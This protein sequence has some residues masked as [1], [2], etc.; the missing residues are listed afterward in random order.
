MKLIKAL[1][2][3]ALIVEQDGVEKIVLGKGIGF[4]LKAGDLIDEKKIDRIFMA[5]TDEK[6]R[7]IELIN[8]IPDCCLEVSEEIIAYARQILQKELSHSIYISLTDH[9]YFILNRSEKD[10]F[11]KNPFKY[12]IQRFYEAEY[13]IGKKAVALLEDEFEIKLN[14][15]EAA[16]IAMHIVN[17]EFEIDTYQNVEMMK[18]ME[19][20]LQIIRY[21]LKIDIAEDSMNYQR[22]ITHLKFFVQ[23]V[24]AQTQYEEENPLYQVVKD[25]YPKACECVER[26]KE[27]VE[28]EYQ[29]HVSK[30]ECTFLM[31]HV[32]R[33]MNREKGETYE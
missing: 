9:I 6:N 19:D 29:V 13:K 24:M 15:D 26:I 28:K 11:P 30:D 22:L 8:E 18:L 10:L 5:G 23:R 14:D 31:I 33:L 1:N 16:S 21:Q 3:S 25:N 2:N 7:L 20:I 27:L 17:A 12:D 4:G 32:Q